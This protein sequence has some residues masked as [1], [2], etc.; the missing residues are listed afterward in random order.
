MVN[1]VI[2]LTGGLRPAV[3]LVSYINIHYIEL[4]FPY[5]NKHIQLV[6]FVYEHVRSY[7]RNEVSYIKH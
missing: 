7:I 6:S 5:A 1:V 2:T 4:C 3:G